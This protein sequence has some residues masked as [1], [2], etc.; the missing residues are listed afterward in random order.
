MFAGL[1]FLGMFSAIDIQKVMNT[2]TGMPVSVSFASFVVYFDRI[3]F[4]LQTAF[5]PAY[6]AGQFICDCRE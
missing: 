2:A 5:S 1:P 6:N 4:P 3:G